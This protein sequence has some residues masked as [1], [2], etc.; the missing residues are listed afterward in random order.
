MS[1]LSGI[2]TFFNKL[3]NMRTA[4]AASPAPG[5]YHYQRQA[6]GERSRV[7]LRL[8]ADGSGLLLV[9]ASRVVH[10]NPTAA[11]MAF[12]YL[13]DM[14]EEQAQRALIRRYAVPPQQARLDYQQVAHQISE[15]VRPEGAC[16]VHDLEVET[17]RPFSA[18]P[19]ALPHGPGA[20]LPLQQHCAHCYNARR[21][22]RAITEEWKRII[23]RLWR[24]IPRGFTGGGPPNGDLR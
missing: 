16:P 6:L 22:L 2:Q 8:D 19:S 14:P 9:N 5:L 4:S 21:G 11:L 20:H 1:K 24:G 13:E 17:I 15:L 12:L 3:G 10:L 23:D 7:H 18:R